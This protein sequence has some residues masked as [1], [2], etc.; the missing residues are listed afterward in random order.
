MEK[1]MT[2]LK[3]LLEDELRK[4]VE[5]NDI[6]PVELENATKAVCLMQKVQELEEWPS[7]DEM[8]GYYS[9][10]S[11]NSYGY[12]PYSMRSYR[13]GRDMNTGRYMSRADGRMP[14]R[15]H[16]VDVDDGY[17]GHSIKDRMIANLEAMM[18]E[19]GGE[20]ERKTIG[21]WI[22]RLEMEK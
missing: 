10:R 17:S 2:D 14:H 21:E 3:H 7:D 15:D 6:S 9:R 12:D 19:A 13:R 4:I 16:M 1:V 8:N 5:K 20:Y 11:Y 22:N 18:D